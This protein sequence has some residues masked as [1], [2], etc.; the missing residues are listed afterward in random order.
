MKNRFILLLAAILLSL[1][2]FAQEKTKA[3]VLLLIDIQDFYFPGGKSALV[4]PIPAAENAAAILH[5]F[6]KENMP[7][8]HIKHKFEPGGDI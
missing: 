5:K 8:I 7:V 6:R 2:S 4:D 1:G 3:E